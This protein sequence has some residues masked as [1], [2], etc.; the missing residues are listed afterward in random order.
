MDQND[1]EGFVLVRPIVRELQKFEQAEPAM[2]YYFPNLVRGINTQAETA[3]LQNV[4]FA[5]AEEARATQ[6]TK[7][8]EPPSEL[9]TWLQEGDRAIASKDGPAA[10]AAFQ[11]VLAKY[12]DQPRA[13]FGLAIS[14]VMVG[15]VERAR[16]LFTKLV[17]AAPTNGSEVTTAQ[18]YP[19]ILS[20]SHVY[21]GHFHDLDGKREEALKEYHAALEVEGAPEEARKAAQRGLEQAYGSGAKPKK[22]PQR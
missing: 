10:E 1:A 19:L 17:A 8:V 2:S 14:S 11:R 13:L 7:A 22:P 3:R 16:D 12:P 9:E 4:K 20:W 15:E 6:E 5:P 18:R 21:L